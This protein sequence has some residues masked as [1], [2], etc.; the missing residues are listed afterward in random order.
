MVE[1]HVRAAESGIGDEGVV[2]LGDS[3]VGVQLARGEDAAVGVN[4]LRPLLVGEGGGKKV[5]STRACC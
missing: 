1:V 3:A 5:C 2:V 4:N